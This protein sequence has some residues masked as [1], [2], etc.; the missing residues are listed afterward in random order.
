[1]SDRSICSSSLDGNSVRNRSTDHRSRRPGLCSH[2]LFSPSSFCLARL[3][4]LQ[5]VKAAVTLIKQARRMTWEGPRRLRLKGARLGTLA[6][7]RIHPDRT[8]SGFN[9]TVYELL[10]RPFRRRVIASFG[11]IIR[12]QF[13]CANRLRFNNPNK[14]TG[15][16]RYRI[17]VLKTLLLEPLCC[18]IYPHSL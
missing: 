9:T 16:L 12:E 8:E 15:L 7:R 17:V 2:R 1:M 4:F 18:A 10:R 14:P 5:V 11:R 3:S 6:V 13:S